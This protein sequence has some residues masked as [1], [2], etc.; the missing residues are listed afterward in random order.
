MPKCKIESSEFFC[1]CGKST[2]RRKVAL[3]PLLVFL[4]HRRRAVR[5][6]F[7]SPAT[8]SF[9]AF[10]LEWKTLPGVRRIPR[11][12]RVLILHVCVYYAVFDGTPLPNNNSVGHC[13]VAQTKNLRKRPLICPFE[14]EVLFYRQ[15]FVIH[16]SPWAFASALIE[17]FSPYTLIFHHYRG[18]RWPESRDFTTPRSGLYWFFDFS[19]FLFF[20]LPLNRRRSLKWKFT[21]DCYVRN[22]GRMASRGI[23]FLW[24]WMLR[25]RWF[26]N[27]LSVEQSFI[28]RNRME[29]MRARKGRECMLIFDFVIFRFTF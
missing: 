12:G 2:N 15:A 14:W 21:R 1:N 17:E 18:M 29:K 16:K 7:F 19:R 11:S 3:P 25:N 26:L 20:F 27:F 10:G 24:R 13:R 28:F 6:P 8:V 9:L 4:Y 5:R 23:L 22:M